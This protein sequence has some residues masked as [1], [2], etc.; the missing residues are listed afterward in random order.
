MA[1]V[2]TRPSLRG[3]GQ[4]Q[5]RSE[6]D[7]HDPQQLRLF[8]PYLVPFRIAVS[9]HCHPLTLF[10]AWRTEGGQAAAIEWLGRNAATW[11]M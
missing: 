5:E 1:I 7:D 11:E 9:H 6:C 8:V 2:L 10:L 4:R 3:R